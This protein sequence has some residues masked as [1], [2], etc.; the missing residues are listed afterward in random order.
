MKLCMDIV[1]LEVDWL[2]DWLLDSEST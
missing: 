2:V 1:P